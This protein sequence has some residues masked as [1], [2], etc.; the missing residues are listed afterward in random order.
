MA[1]TVSTARNHFAPRSNRPSPPRATKVVRFQRPGTCLLPFTAYAPSLLISLLV[2]RRAAGL[3]EQ[4][5][6]PPL[7]EKD[8]RDE[9]ENLCQHGPGEGL[10]Q[11]VDDPHRH[12]ADERAPEISDAAKN[13]HHER[14]DDIR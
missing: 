5:A 12:A 6:R 4:S 14:V 9:H 2:F 11:L 1:T 13:N 7:D 8:Q 10:Q 3:R